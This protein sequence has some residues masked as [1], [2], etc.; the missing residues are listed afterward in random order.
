MSRRTTMTQPR[1]PVTLPLVT[2][3]IGTDDQARVSSAARASS[4]VRRNDV[5]RVVDAIAEDLG[6]LRLEVTE[7]DGTVFT[8]VVVPKS[9]ESTSEDQHAGVIGVDTA[10][11][12]DAR[13]LPHEDLCLAVVVAH[14][15]ADADGVAN[16]RV[17]PAIVAGND[18]VVVLF[19][20]SSG[21]F[22]VCDST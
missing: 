15:K 6:P 12:P 7:R 8:D 11:P 10:R 5:R 21:S 4:V 19:G 14:Q 1:A 18:R 22:M 2:V 20:R 13:F 16:L 3:R 9:T 17:P